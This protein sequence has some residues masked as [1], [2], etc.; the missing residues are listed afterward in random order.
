MVSNFVLSFLQ[1]WRIFAHRRGADLYLPTFIGVRF[2]SWECWDFWRRHDHFWSLPKTLTLRMLFCQIF[3]LPLHFPSPSLRMRINERL[4]PTMSS[5]WRSAC[6]IFA[7]NRRVLSATP[8]SLLNEVNRFSLC[9][10]A[11]NYVWNEK[12]SYHCLIM[13]LYSFVSI[14]RLNFLSIYQIVVLF[15][16]WRF[17]TLYEVFITT[18]RLNWAVSLVVMADAFIRW[19]SYILVAEETLPFKM[20]IDHTL[21]V[22]LHCCCVYWTNTL[23]VLDFVL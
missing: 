19:H 4:L 15:K 7:L 22:Q 10:A 18:L 5:Q 13:N 14:T 1:R 20:L 8:I 9:L 6:T 3:I 12:V 2:S 17:F 11:T 23:W 21:V 16:V